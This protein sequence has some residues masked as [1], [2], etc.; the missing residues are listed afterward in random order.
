[1]KENF[2]PILKEEKDEK[3]K[4]EGSGRKEYELFKK[5]AEKSREENDKPW[6]IQNLVWE[7]AENLIKKFGAEKF[8]DAIRE[9]EESDKSQS[10][11]EVIKVLEPDKKKRQELHE[12]ALN[13]D[14]TLLEES[15]NIILKNDIRIRIEKIKFFKYLDSFS[16]LPEKSLLKMQQML[17]RD[18]GIEGETYFDFKNLGTD[19]KE[20]LTECDGDIEK[21]QENIYQSNR[22]KKGE[23]IEKRQK[24]IDDLRRE[25]KQ[26]S[27][28][29]KNEYLRENRDI[30]KKLE[31]TYKAKPVAEFD[32]IDFM[33]K[34]LEKNYENVE[35]EIDELTKEQREMID[36]IEKTHI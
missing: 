34:T 31:E 12:E 19:F 24:L 1:M 5:E 36:E 2:M 21:L 15:G 29:L 20:R 28:E 30:I 25:I 23:L 33:E 10:M 9:V 35:K 26:I 11:Y 7:G 14:E 17:G 3:R 18:A 6:V 27:I 13:D 4:N 16:S 32:V 8:T 22:I